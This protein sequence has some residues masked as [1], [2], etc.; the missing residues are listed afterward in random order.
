MSYTVVNT[1]PATR[2]SLLDGAGVAQVRWTLQ[3]PEREGRSL[4][5]IPD[6]ILAP[7][8]SATGWRRSWE[9]RGFRL[10]LGLKWGYGLTS[11]REAWTGSAWGAPVE[12]PTATAHSEILDWSARYPVQ[13]EPFLGQP[14]PSFQAQSY[15]KGPSLADT[16]G[17]AHPSLELVLT[18]IVLL[19]TVTLRQSLGWG[20]GPWG[21]LPWGD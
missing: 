11:F 18:A 7:L 16:K 3:A 2:I 15:E 17:I 12:L 4:R 5:W 1:A 8:G 20:I 6:G 9:H 14:M 21:L 13:V 19:S 10:E